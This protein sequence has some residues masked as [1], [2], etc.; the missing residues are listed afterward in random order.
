MTSPLKERSQ[1]A[2]E[3]LELIKGYVSQETIDP[4]KK[5]LRNLTSALGVIVAGLIMGIGNIMTT[6]GLL[7]LLQTLK[8]FRGT[9]SFT[10]YLIDIGAIVILATLQLFVLNL[11]KKRRANGFS[12]G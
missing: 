10:A 5:S 2:K 6:L 12:K 9:L 8:F 4:L 7:R 3:A 11:I 1:S